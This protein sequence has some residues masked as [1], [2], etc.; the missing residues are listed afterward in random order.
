[1]AKTAIVTGASRGIGKA[2]GKGDAALFDN[3]IQTNFK[4][5]PSTE[6]PQ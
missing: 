3:V 6:V 4:A 1:M 2:V 5:Q